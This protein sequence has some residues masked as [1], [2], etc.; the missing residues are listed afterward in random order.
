MESPAHIDR[1]TQRGK[2]VQQLLNAVMP[3]SQIII[4][5]KP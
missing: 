1:N 5:R 4:A 3:K 2:Q